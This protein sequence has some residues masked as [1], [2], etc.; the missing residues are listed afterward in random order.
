N[1]RFDPE[2]LA[3]DSDEL[4]TFHQQAAE[5]A[6][7]LIAGDEDSDLFAP[8]K[9]FEVS[10]DAAGVAHPAAGEDDMPV[11]KLLEAIALLRLHEV[12]QVGGVAKLREGIGLGVP[13]PT[14]L[15]EDIGGLDRQ[16]RVEED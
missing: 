1:P 4:L 3:L 8:E 16:G 10:P 5:R 15:Q 12:V 6:D 2:I 7:R 13:V 9:P 11:A 14:A